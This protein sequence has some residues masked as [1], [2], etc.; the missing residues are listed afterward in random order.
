MSAVLLTVI[1]LACFASGYLVYSKWLATRIY[2]LNPNAV[3]PA[4]QLR[5]DIDYIPTNKFILWGHHFTSVAGV[6]PIIGPAIALYWGWLPGLLWV[7]LGTIFAAGAHDFGAIVLSLRHKGQSIGGLANQ[8]IGGRAKVLIL[9]I[10]LL[11]VLV[12][13]AVF[14]WVVANLLINFPAT[15][16]PTLIQIPFAM[17]LGYQVYKR[18]RK[19]FLPSLLTI[20]L[21]CIIAV[22]CSQVDALQLDLVAGLN[23]IGLSSLFGLQAKSLAFAI[24]IGLIMAYIYFAS[25]LPVWKLLQPRD[26]LN[27]KLL[28]IGLVILYAGVFISNPTLSAPAINTQATDLSWWP[29]LFIT[30]ACGAISGFH[31]LV[32]SGTTSKQIDKE[33]DARFVG[34]S[35][36]LGEGVL[37]VIAI[38]AVATAFVVPSDYFTVYSSF[39]SASDNAMS[40]FV[41]G[42]ARLAHGVGVSLEIGR[43][44]VALIIISFAATTLD[45][46]M[47]IMRYIVGE[48]GTEYRIPWLTHKHKA[49]MV[50]VLA[51]AALIFLPP[52]PHGLGSGGYLLWPLLGTTN[53]LLA[54]IT[55]LL[56]TLWLRSLNRNIFPTLIPMIFVLTVTL[57]AM[58]QQVVFVWSGLSGLPANIICFVLGALIL[59]FAVWILMEAFYHLRRPTEQIQFDKLLD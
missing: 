9:F 44:I 25:T 11:L 42:A 20:T 14:A 29:F 58:I 24:W 13:N 23:A 12:V 7:V 51:C 33:P 31:S 1:C 50:S 8:I 35:A 16:I 22:V 38:V 52:G 36:A 53:Q 37:A 26:Y 21:V 48:L 54:G 15:V 49:T 32:G 6:A 10:I 47:R 19:I 2:Q 30:I 18:Q 59:A 39:A 5:D 17:W 41:E 57:W 55:L 34:Y 3:T 43:T 27:A 40:T 28:L 4:H 56:L 45:S 46:S